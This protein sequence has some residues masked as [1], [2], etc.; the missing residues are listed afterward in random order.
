MRLKRIEL[1]DYRNIAGSALDFEGNR[2]FFTGENGQGKTNLL[3]AIS[4]PS[5]L[6]S[7]RTRSREA[8][9]SHGRPHAL[10]RSFWEHESLGEVALGLKLEGAR[11]SLSLAGKVVRKPAE[12][13]ARFPIVSLS[14]ADR[15][16]IYGGPEAR[17]DEID[18][19]IAQFDPTYLK[20]LSDFERALRSRNALLTESNSRDAQFEA[21]EETMEPLAVRMTKNRSRM[22][23]LLAP[24]IGDVLK[25]FAP[26]TEELRLN[27][28][29]N[30]PLD[31]LRKNWRELRHSKDAALGWTSC[32]PQRDEFELS[33]NTR[34]VG[35][36][37]SEGQKFS[38]VLAL[39]MAGLALVREKLAVAP[40]LVC[41]DL[42][43]ELDRGRQEKF[44]AGLGEVQVFASS[45]TP[46]ALAQG[47][48]IFE[49]CDGAFLPATT[50]SRHP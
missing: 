41:D 44:W 39:K 19:M 42:L 35:L 27:Y 7:F 1:T 47:W 29:P 22:V 48:Q 8:L 50:Y 16:L 23:E 46:P 30:C 26:A 11:L 25:E 31:A 24:R 5:R 43:L 38:V 12:V 21:F 10:L 18:A 34:P 28:R 33:L 15:A 40:V 49:V 45:T 3:E 6:H 36:Y 9:I 20:T 4:L 32:G 17:R 2:I 13:A 14:L 37:A